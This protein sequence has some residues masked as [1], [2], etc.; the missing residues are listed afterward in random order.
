MTSVFG[1]KGDSGQ[2]HRGDEQ[3]D[4]NTMMKEKKRTY[5][6]DRK[7]KPE[8]CLINIETM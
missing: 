6:Q 2:G 3:R 8:D 7:R 5:T 1:E 4:P